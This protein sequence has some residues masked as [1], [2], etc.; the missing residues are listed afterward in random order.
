MFPGDL[1][2]ITGRIPEGLKKP[3][4]GIDQTPKLALFR[5]PYSCFYFFMRISGIR[6]IKI[7]EVSS[8]S[9]VRKDLGIL[10]SCH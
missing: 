4:S 3:G 1:Q 7:S 9:G 5:G 8:K 2:E 6:R 10:G